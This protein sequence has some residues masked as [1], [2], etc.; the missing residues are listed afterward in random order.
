MIFARICYNGICSLFSNGS[1]YMKSKQSRLSAFRLFS[2]C[3]IAL[4]AF[5]A[6]LASESLAQ[7][8]GISE[9]KMQAFGIR[10]IE[11]KHLILYTDI[12]PAAS[13]DELPK[14][15]D[16]AVPQWCDY[17][18]TDMGK[19]SSWF[20]RAGAIPGDLPPFLNGYARDSEIW[21][22]E[23]PSDYYRRHLLLH[24]GTHAFMVWRYA[25]VG[26]PWYMEGTAEYFGTH[27]WENGELQL[28][29]LPVSK[30][31]T[32][33]WGRIR[34]L[35]DEVE[36]NR[37]MSLIGI[38][39]YD[40]QAHLR[41]EPYAW[42]WAISSFFQ[43]HPKTRKHFES[44]REQCDLSNNEF[45]T[46]FYSKLKT[47]W[48]DLEEQWQLFYSQMEYGYDLQREII[49]RK[50]AQVPPSTG[51]SATI[52]ADRGWQSTGIRLESGAT[53][54][55]TATGRYQIA[56]DPKIWW[57][58]PGGVTIDYYRGRPVGQLV[59]A[60]R[61]DQ[62][63]LQRLTPLIKPQSIGLGRVI[64]PRSSGTLYL[65][66]NE[67]AAALHDNSGELTVRVVTK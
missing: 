45:N 15:F 21:V 35:K 62:T 6:G 5:V 42:C 39:K 37:A 32:P 49:V 19:A 18:K 66:I 1:D 16:L 53:Y 24:E 63:P 7:L 17:F 41:N 27:Q 34:I 54:E 20:G 31:Q 28:G 59:G 10:K 30:E 46:S 48:E 58:E 50:S 65:R 14:V 61:D 9:D 52:A 43:N 36:A 12:P 57:S 56:G 11:S 44:L 47:E 13:V 3:V 55:I 2:L 64:R 33:D 25:A 67:S 60:L 51:A 8:P 38:M 40:S 4:A 23:Q 22:Y 26:P 29:Y